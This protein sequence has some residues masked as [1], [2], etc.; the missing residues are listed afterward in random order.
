MVGGK[1]E[2]VDKYEGLYKDL[3]VENGYGYMGKHGAGHFVKMVHNGIEYGMMQAIAEGFELM[4]N[5]EFNLDLTK[6]TGV[7]N[8]GSVV[9]SHLILWLK[10]AY[11]QYGED[12][13]EISGKVSHS[14]E[15][16]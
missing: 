15:G 2:L 8:N 3:S 10:Q 5:S 1:K 13:N 9:E 16:L 14:G 7:Y 12:L 6:I 11:E 4:K